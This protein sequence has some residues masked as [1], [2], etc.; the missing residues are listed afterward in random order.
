MY[1]C[2]ITDHEKNRLLS[3]SFC[4]NGI[5]QDNICCA[6]N[7]GQCGGTGCHQFPGGNKCC[8]GAIN[9]SGRICQTGSETAC[10]MPGK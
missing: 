3:G 9:Q 2:Q 5:C 1:A 8:T 4:M 6:K 10:I 7:C